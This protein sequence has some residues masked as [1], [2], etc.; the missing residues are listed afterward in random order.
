MASSSGQRTLT[1]LEL[2]LVMSQSRFS[3]R[4]NFPRRP[5]A[6]FF[7]PWVAMPK[8]LNVPH[9]DLANRRHR[10]SRAAYPIGIQCRAAIDWSRTSRKGA[11]G[12]ASCTV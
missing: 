9:L 10:E 3:K 11:H 1:D 6:R 5:W 2:S 7:L 8:L 4:R 12:R